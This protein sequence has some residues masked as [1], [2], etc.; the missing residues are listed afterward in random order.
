MQAP[1]AIAP[2]IWSREL[3]EL[4]ESGAA[5]QFILHG[6]VHDLVLLDGA[7]GGRL[8]ELDEYLKQALLGRFDVVLSYDLGNGLRVEKGGDHYAQWPSAREPG[9]TRVPRE[10]IETLTHYLR[11]TANLAAVPNGKVL[12]VACLLRQCHLFIPAGNPG[13]SYE[14]NA[15]ASLVREWA[16]DPLIT[17]HHA[18][19]FLMVENLHD[20]HSL[21]SGHA[22]AARIAL[23]L[24][25][26]GTVEHALR[27]WQDTYA[28]PLAPWRDKLAEPAGALAGA[29]LYSIEKLLRLHQHASEP[30]LAADLAALKKQLV[31]DE[32][33][34]LIDFLKPDRTL[35]DLH[36]QDAIKK[37]LREDISLWKQGDLG[38]L[39]MGYLICGPVGTGKTFMVECLAGEADVPVVKLKN[40]R[41]RWVGSTES[42]LEKIFRL[43]AALGRC[44][45]FVDEADQALG[46]RQ[47]DA[48]DNGVSGRVYSMLAEHMSN[49][50]MR[51]RIMWVLATSRPDLVEVDLKRPGR[52]DVKIPLFPTSTLEEAWALLC[53]LGRRKNLTFTDEDFAVTKVMLPDLLTPGAAEAL[54]VRVYRTVKISSQTPGAAL[55]EALRNYQAPVSSS[56]MEK[57]IALAA[58]EAS[59]RAFIPERFLPDA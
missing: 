43:L 44:I 21:V 1:S 20:L 48:G 29:S 52:V 5:S 47:A 22:R 4:Y 8:L 17:R 15:T 59:D 55:R 38:A 9:K 14:L 18:A 42:N 19:T 26:A 50:R 7:G 39:P 6:N 34:G 41:D 10:A 23:P 56:V 45:V 27:V 33:E 2:P 32:C 25:P 46:R 49:T 37:W 12:R 3:M 31:E 35:E 36:G 58:E 53:A 51:G 16:S 28:Q 11:F 24:P 13:V 54:M 40:F 57:Q 30:L